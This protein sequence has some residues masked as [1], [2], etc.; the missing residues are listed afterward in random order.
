MRRKYDVSI[1]INGLKLNEVII[2]THYE[3]KHFKSINDEIILKLVARLDNNYFEAEDYKY[4]YK[5]FVTDKVEIY[6]KFY[7]IIW[8][9]EENCSYVGVINAYRRS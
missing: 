3:E 1:T 4:P 6:Q 7:K 2:D 5:Y 8:L 9:L